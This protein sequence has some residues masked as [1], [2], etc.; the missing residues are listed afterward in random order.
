V[1]ALSLPQESLEG[2]R[3]VEFEVKSAQD[4]VE[5]DF[6]G[7]NLMLVYADRAKATR[8]LPYNAPIGKWERRYVTLDDGMDLADVEAIR[9]GVNP[10]G[11]KCTFWIRNLAI[12]R[13]KGR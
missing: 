11:A 9:I 6:I 2:A 7:Q 1:H 12:L 8:M 13:K 5:N 10:K 3:M 4:K